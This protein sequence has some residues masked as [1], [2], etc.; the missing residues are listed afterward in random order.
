MATDIGTQLADIL[1]KL[2]S[3]IS[4]QCMDAITSAKPFQAWALGKDLETARRVLRVW[5]GVPDPV[6]REAEFEEALA[7][8]EE[9]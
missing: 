2:E 8:L 1:R 4:K 7:A 3:R 5:D 6:A 9:K